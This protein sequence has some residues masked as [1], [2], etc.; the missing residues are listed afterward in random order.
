[1]QYFYLDIKKKSNR[2]LYVYFEQLHFLTPSITNKNT[3]SNFDDNCTQSIIEESQA[4]YQDE[5][6]EH[7]CVDE[8]N[9]STS[10]PPSKVFKRKK[11]KL[12]QFN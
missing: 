8:I 3:T 10:A 9:Q 2:R 1:V 4:T 6:E 5:N 11:M 12:N 7:I